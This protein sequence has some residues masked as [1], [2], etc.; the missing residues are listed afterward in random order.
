MRLLGRGAAGLLV[1]AVLAGCFGSST[2]EPPPRP[3]GAQ[4]S[5]IRSAPADRI[6]SGGTLSLGAMGWPVSFN[7]WQVDEARSGAAL[8][9]LAPTF[10][11]AV[12]PTEDGGWELDRDYADSVEVVGDD[13][14]TIE[15]RINPEAVWQDGTPISGEDLAAFVKAAK[16]PDSGLAAHPAYRLVEEV[17]TGDDP[18]AY[19]VVFSRTTA[20]WPA[21]V[22]PPLPGSVSGDNKKL[23]SGF[24]EEAVPAN[25]PFMVDEIDEETGAVEL[26]RNPRWWGRTPKLERIV[27]RAAEPEVLAKAYADEE[28]DAVQVDAETL[29]AASPAPADLRYG[30]DNDWA[31]LTLN[32]GRGPLGDTA[33]RQAVSAALDRG[34]IA[35]DM[36]ERAAGA[37][38]AQHSVVMLPRQR[39]HRAEALDSGRDRAEKLL[40]DAGWALADGEDIRSKDGKPLQLTFPVPDGDDAARRRADL[41]AEQLRDVGIE[42]KVDPR[43]AE[44]F[45]DQVVVALDFDIVGFTWEGS[46]F[47]VE[48]AAARFTP[49]DSNQNF[50]GIATE[51]LS[52]AFDGLRGALD[53]GDAAEATAQVD[54]AAAEQASVIPLAPVP[55]TMAVDPRIRNLGPSAFAPL[56]WTIVGFE[57]KR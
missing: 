41:V 22:F 26:V 32:G 46:A 13:P 42:A 4:L 55:T 43:E 34:A 56:D 28:L 33:V 25:G 53:E 2:P 31:Q 8:Q 17:R 5:D 12:R 27:W 1:M 24:T 6:A 30:V 37:T 48:A 29:D 52:K 39:G 36:A 54:A 10:G 11:S 19:Q 40:D 16:N 9:I 14:L 23:T 7:P 35:R 44:N 45:T 3:G 38:E 21:A 15:V 50:T 47:P 49:V 51:K 57:E 20:D 18:A